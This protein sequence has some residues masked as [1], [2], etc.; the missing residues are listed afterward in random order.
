MVKKNSNFS[1]KGFNTILKNRDDLF[2]EVA[3]LVS[4]NITFKE[5]TVCRSLNKN[6]EVCARR[7]EKSNLTIVSLYNPSK[8]NNITSND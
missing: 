7:L 4:N 1:I 3:I 6:M 5:I 2:G 8:N